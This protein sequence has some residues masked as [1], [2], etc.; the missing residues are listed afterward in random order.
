MHAPFH[1]QGH[2]SLWRALSTRVWEGHRLEM[3]CDASCALGWVDVFA[4]VAAPLLPA[5]QSECRICIYIHIYMYAYTYL[6]INMY[7]HVI[8]ALGWVDVFANVAAPLLPAGQS[9]CRNTG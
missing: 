4:N 1:P 5:G 6:Y 2:A 8:Y 9:A 3:H 7:I